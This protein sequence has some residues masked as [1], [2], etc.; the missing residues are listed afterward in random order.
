MNLR[1]AI[2][3]SDWTDSELG[4]IVG[5]SHT[6]IASIRTGKSLPSRVV[7]R[8]LAAALEIPFDSIETRECGRPRKQA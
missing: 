2:E 6:H 5:V 3:S 1:T 8:A 4:R 7:A